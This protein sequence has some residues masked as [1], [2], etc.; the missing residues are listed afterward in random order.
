MQGDD[1]DVACIRFFVLTCG[2]PPRRIV[3]QLLS[4]DEN[5]ESALKVSAAKAVDAETDCS[6][7]LRTSSFAVVSDMLAMSLAVAH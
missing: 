7:A 6:A 2:T 5:L 4:V 1:R 3:I